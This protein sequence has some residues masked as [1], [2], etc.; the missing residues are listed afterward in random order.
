MQTRQLDALANA[1]AAIERF[2]DAI[3]S[4]RQTKYKVT[5][6][7]RLHLKLHGC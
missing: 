3:R 1:G 7:W 6:A 5:K 2:E 4:A